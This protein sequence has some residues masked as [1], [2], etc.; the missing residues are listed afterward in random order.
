MSTGLSIRIVLAASTALV[1]LGGCQL[2]RSDA[3]E[4]ALRELRE[5]VAADI[6]LTVD[7]DSVSA[8]YQG[9]EWV[10]YAVC[11]TARLHRPSDTPEMNLVNSRE[12]FV[13]LLYYKGAVVATFEGR[14]QRTKA[15]FSRLWDSRCR[16]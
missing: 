7:R 10:K 2:A 12:R 11:G 16:G 1:I 3:I 9:D 8:H 14:T 13:S 6:E 15:E 5:Q 4:Q